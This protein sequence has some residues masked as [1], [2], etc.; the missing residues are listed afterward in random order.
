MSLGPALPLTTGRESG[1]TPLPTPPHGRLGV[2]SD[3]SLIFTRGRSPAL[4]STGQLYCVAQVRWRNHSS[5][6]CSQRGAGSPLYSCDPGASFPCLLYAVGHKGQRVRNM[7]LSCLCH[8]MTDSGPNFPTLT[9]SGPAHL[10]LCQEGQ[11]HC[12]APMRCR[13][14]S[15]ECCSW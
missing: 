9:L 12:A 7:S 10:H 4:L 1:V 13:T 11:L 3:L 6:Y 5:K 14:Y 8:C 2:G 15:L